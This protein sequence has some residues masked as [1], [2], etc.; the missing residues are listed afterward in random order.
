MSFYV[1]FMILNDAS[2]MEFSNLGPFD[3]QIKSTLTLCLSEEEVRIISIQQSKTENP[4]IT[5]IL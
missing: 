5:T 2:M 4:N 3:Q 1:E